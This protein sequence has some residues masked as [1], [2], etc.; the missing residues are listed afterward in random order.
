MPVRSDPATA[1]S[2]WVTGMTGSTAAMQRGVNAVTVAPGE[3]AAAAA[4]KWLAK[5][6][7]SKDKFARRVRSVS[8]QQW[9]QSMND[10]G[11]SRVAQGASQ[12]KG[13]MQD[14]MTE[15]L[16]YLQEG[17]NKVERMPKNT[18]QD[19]IQRM[20]TMVEHNAGFQRKG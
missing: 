14:F 6:T 5:V 10:Y 16:P 3:R 4:D 8:L 9:Q 7:Q 17:V 2:R 12:K 13:K 11:I 19:S 20:I 1:T 18:L 15:Y